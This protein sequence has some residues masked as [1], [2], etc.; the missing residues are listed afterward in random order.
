M[1]TKHINT[2]EY[3]PI[4][5]NICE[6]RRIITNTYQIRTNTCTYQ[7][8]LHTNICNTYCFAWYNR[9]QMTGPCCLVVVSICPHRTKGEGLFKFCSVHLRNIF[10]YFWYVTPTVTCIT[11]MPIAHFFLKQRVWAHYYFLCKVRG[12][13]RLY[14]VDFHYFSQVWTVIVDIRK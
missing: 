3:M 6:Y 9:L 13:H 12:L 4:H 8:S 7:V 5:I 2:F 1:H 10:P 11:C 14:Q